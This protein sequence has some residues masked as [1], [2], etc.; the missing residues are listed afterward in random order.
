MA[1][2]LNVLDWVGFEKGEVAGEGV[3]WT[4][5]AMTARLPIFFVLA[6]AWIARGYPL[7]RARHGEILSELA[8]RRPSGPS[9]TAGSSASGG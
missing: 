8:R 7:G 4:L 2:A 1:F 9:G 3:L 6:S 5:R